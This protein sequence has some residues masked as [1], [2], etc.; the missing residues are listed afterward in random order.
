MAGGAGL[1]LAVLGAGALLPPIALPASEAMAD[2]L[3]FVLRA[4]LVLIFWLVAAIASVAK[5]R[6]FSP[7]DI[8]GSGFN[9][10]TPKIAIGRAIVQNTHEQVTIAVGAHLA[11]ATVLPMR[12]MGFIPILVLLFCIGRAAFWFGYAGGAASRAFG[13]E[14]TFFPT[15]IAA[16]LAAA[17]ALSQW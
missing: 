14:T 8:A 15:V 1:S 6:F 9:E 11:L 3:S 17:L 7:H 2:R 16:L 13:F 4:D 12:F 10:P 5:D